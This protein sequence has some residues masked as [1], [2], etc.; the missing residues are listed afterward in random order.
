[1]KSILL[2]IFI[3]SLSACFSKNENK[4]NFWK[5]VD[6]KAKFVGKG[7]VVENAEEKWNWYLPDLNSTA[8][9]T[10]AYY[11]LA[12]D[13]GKATY[14][15]SF[16][17]KEDIGYVWSWQSKGTEV[18]LIYTFTGGHGYSIRT[19]HNTHN[20]TIDEA[21]LATYFDSEFSAI[22]SGFEVKKWEIKDPSSDGYHIESLG[23]LGNTIFHPL[24]D[25]SDTRWFNGRIITVPHTYLRE[26]NKTLYLCE[27]YSE[28]FKGC[29]ALPESVKEKLRLSE[30]TYQEIRQKEIIAQMKIKLTEK[31]EI[32]A[33]IA[34]ALFDHN[35][36]ESRKAIYKWP[37]PEGYLGAGTNTEIQYFD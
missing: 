29:L 4:V 3:L 5:L 2:F 17:I 23:F 30:H 33:F 31:K 26:K 20:I 8:Q 15:R 34:G 19:L 14:R 27:Y 32:T 22:L 25:N 1:M 7:L 35:F 36:Y 18:F 24:S 21:I 13:T 10:S 9:K 16:K 6:T 12:S 37:I 11:E 28:D